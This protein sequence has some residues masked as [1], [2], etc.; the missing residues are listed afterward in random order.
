MSNGVLPRRATSSL[1]TRESASSCS[2]AWRQNKGLQKHV[3][4]KRFNTSLGGVVACETLPCFARSNS[5]C[6]CMLCAMTCFILSSSINA[7]SR[8]S[9]HDTTTVTLD[10]PASYSQHM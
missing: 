7:D 5:C 2:S 3:G 1:R 4:R 10:S 8:S 6:C 9:C